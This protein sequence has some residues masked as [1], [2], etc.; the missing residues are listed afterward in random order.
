MVRT[1]IYRVIGWKTPKER[2]H[3]EYLGIDGNLIFIIKGK[4]IP[5]LARCGPEGGWRYSF[6][7]PRSRH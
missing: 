1:D 5:L 7:L 4:V 3:L 2:D 6:T